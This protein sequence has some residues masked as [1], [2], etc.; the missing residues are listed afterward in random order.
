VLEFFR[1]PSY[2]VASSGVRASARCGSGPRVALSEEAFRGG[3]PGGRGQLGG[4]L[5]DGRAGALPPRR[6]AERSAVLFL[7][8]ERDQRDHADPG[9]PGLVFGLPASSQP[10][11]QHCAGGGRCPLLVLF[12]LLPRYVD[13]IVRRVRPGGSR[14][15]NER[16]QRTRTERL[17]FHP[18]W[19]IVARS[20]LVVRHRGAVHVAL[21]P[22]ARCRRWPGGVGVPDRLLSTSSRCRRDR[23]ARRKHDWHAR[24]LRPGRDG[25]HGGHP[26]YTRFRCG[27]PPVWGTIAFIVLQKTKRQRSS[28][29]TPAR[30]CGRAPLIYGRRSRRRDPLPRIGLHP[31]RAGNSSPSAAC[32]TMQCRSAGRDRRRIA[33]R[34]LQAGRMGQDL[35][36]GASAAAPLEIEAPD[37]RRRQR[38][39]QSRLRRRRRSAGGGEIQARAAPT[40]PSHRGIAA[41]C[42]SW[43]RRRIPTVRRS[44]PSYSH[45][46]ACRYAG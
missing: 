14:L 36:E 25:G 39:R 46:V 30:N 26:R 45:D 37:H 12:L 18:N 11:A 44:P 33:R 6:I 2:V 31:L 7:Y 34:D 42:A 13:R 16:R 5:A 3:V 28:C 23:R 10:A 17:M 43:S 29:A 20:L 19:R 38:A 22:P 35:W 21:P 24:S 15:L 9:R 27:S 8:T 32:M 40:L 41:N 1:A 4:A